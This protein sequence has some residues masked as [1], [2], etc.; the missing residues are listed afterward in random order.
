MSL[1][2][3]TAGHARRKAQFS[4]SPPLCTVPH[5]YHYNM[6]IS[7]SFFFMCVFERGK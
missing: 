1:M 7:F 2:T 4:S 6:L 3:C 5:L